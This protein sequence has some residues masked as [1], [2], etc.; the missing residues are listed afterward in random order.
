MNKR[1]CYLTPVCIRLPTNPGLYDIGVREQERLDLGRIDILTARD[2]EIVATIQHI[3]IAI[4]IQ[5]TDI[6]GREPAIMD[7]L[8]RSFGAMVIATR[9]A[10]TLSTDHPWLTRHRILPLLIDDA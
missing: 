9:D 4:L 3:Q 2:N 10:G 8:C 7:S 5:I 1:D 6:T